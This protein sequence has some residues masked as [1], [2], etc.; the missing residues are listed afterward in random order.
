MREI[1][2]EHHGWLNELRWHSHLWSDCCYSVLDFE[3]ERIAFK[4]RAPFSHE[5][6]KVW[7]A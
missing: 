2:G 7:P 1:G 3:A 5:P 4:S 6:L